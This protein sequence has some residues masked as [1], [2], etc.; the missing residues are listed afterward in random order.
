[1]LDPTL[2]LLLGKGEVEVLD[3]AFLLLLGKGEVLDPD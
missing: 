1:M 3:S 2:I